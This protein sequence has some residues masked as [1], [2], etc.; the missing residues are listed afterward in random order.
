VGV[1]PSYYAS[2]WRK[3]DAGRHYNEALI[4]AGGGGG[5][6][7]LQQHRRHQRHYRRYQHHHYRLNRQDCRQEDRI[8]NG[9]GNN[10]HGAHYIWHTPVPFPISHFPLP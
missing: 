3:S 7:L 1:F 2:K 10:N 8:A 9:S 4:S 5:R 6:A